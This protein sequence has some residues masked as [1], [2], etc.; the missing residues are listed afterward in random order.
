[1]QLELEPLLSEQHGGPLHHH[2]AFEGLPNVLTPLTL[3]GTR[4]LGVRRGFEVA[5]GADAAIQWLPL[6]LTFTHGTRPV[7]F[8]AFL[9]IRPPLGHMGR[10][11]NMRMGGRH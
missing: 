10:M 2:E 11:W 9:R 4:E 1:M 7:S 6:A 8:H 3:G 5:V